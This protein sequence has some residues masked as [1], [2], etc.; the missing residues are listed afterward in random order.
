ME[1]VQETPSNV[2]SMEI[3]KDEVPKPVPQLI[4][5]TL[6]CGTAYEPLLR[7][8]WNTI[9]PYVIELASKTNGEYSEY[10]VYLKLWNGNCSLHMAYMDDSCKVTEANSGDMVVKHLSSP[11]KDFVGY[12]ITRLDEKSVHIWQVV[13]MP[14][15]QNTNAFKLGYKFLE[16]YIK[17]TGAKEITFSTQREGWHK[18]CVDLGFA[19]LYTVYRKSLKV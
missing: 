10:D 7:I 2:I 4:M 9:K 13:I 6:P 5:G 18:Q 17:Y 19:E 15:Y 12:V 14:E 11:L 3:K 8:A 1:I 16:D